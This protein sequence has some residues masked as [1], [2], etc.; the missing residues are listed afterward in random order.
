MSEEEESVFET[1]NKNIAVIAEQMATTNEALIVIA[2]ELYQARRELTSIFKKM[3]S[4]LGT[5]AKTEFKPEVT[6]VS[7][8]QDEERFKE[9]VFPKSTLSKAEEKKK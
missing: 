4:I 7:A 8:V 3:N 5:L 2:T 6:E 9:A 1:L